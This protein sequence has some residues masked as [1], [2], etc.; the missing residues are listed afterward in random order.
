L[1]SFGSFKPTLAFGLI[2]LRTKVYLWSYF[3]KNQSLPLELQKG[4]NK[5]FIFISLVLR[6]SLFIL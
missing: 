4:N 1:G 6:N 3:F 2:F 5:E